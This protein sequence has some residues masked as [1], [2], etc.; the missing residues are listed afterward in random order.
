MRDLINQNE[1]QISI[2]SVGPATNVAKLLL[3]YPEVVKKIKKVV[4]MVG[5]LDGKGSITPYSSFNAYCDPEAVD[6]V[7][8]SKVPVT[9]SPTQMGITAFFDEKQRSRFKKCGK[10]GEFIYD[11]CEGYKDSLLE[12]GQYAL[13]DTCALFSILDT[14]IFTRQKVDMKIN[15]TKDEKRGQTL[16]A[17]NEK[18]HVTL[19]KKVEKKKLFKIIEETLKNV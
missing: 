14:D 4:L 13:H 7:I 16:F 12:V 1:N 9:I 10:Y 19:L 5:T 2:V 15:T 11:L 6:V 17:N 18:S 8:K 3:K